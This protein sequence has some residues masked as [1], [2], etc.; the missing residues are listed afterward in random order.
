MA[1]VNSGKKWRIFETAQNNRLMKEIGYRF[2][3]IKGIHICKSKHS[4]ALRKV[5]S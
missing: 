2:M 1:C 5:K 3:A 4:H